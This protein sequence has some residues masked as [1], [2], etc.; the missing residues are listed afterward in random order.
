MARYWVNAPS[1][2]QEDHMYTGMEVLAPC[3]LPEEKYTYAYP[4]EGPIISLM[5]ECLT[6]APGWK[7]DRPHTTGH[8]N[9]RPDIP[10]GV[11]R[12]S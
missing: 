7:A 11:H 2:L 8:N 9:E 1:T 4:R 3:P 12:A 10:Q 6:L 5:L